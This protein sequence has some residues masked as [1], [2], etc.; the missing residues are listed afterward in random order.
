MP[1][2]RLPYGLGS[3]RD[4]PDP[5]D[6]PYTGA[7]QAAVEEPDIPLAIDNRL[8]FPYVYDQGQEYACVGMAVAVYSTT[9]R[10]RAR[11]YCPDLSPR[12][13]YDKA[14]DHDM[15]PGDFYSGSTL[16]GG[17]KGARKKGTCPWTYWPYKAFDEGGKD[18]W[19]DRIAMNYRISRYERLVALPEI[20]HAIAEHGG[21][22]ATVCTH[23]GWIEPKPENDYIIRYQRNYAFR[24]LHTIILAG[25][26]DPEEWFLVHNSW[27]RRWAD[28]GTAKLPYEDFCKN[29]TDA[30]LAYVAVG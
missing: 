25:Y 30:W 6:Y 12:D 22:V 24:G 8:M 3:N 14:K 29:C 26:N 1:R 21:V 13:A 27:S 11:G 19:A 9:L 2:K 4:V 16:A 23:T 7:P 5:R 28:A 10:E 17:L 18:I 20:K 15:I